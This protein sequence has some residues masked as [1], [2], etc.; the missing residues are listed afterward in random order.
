MSPVS[1]LFAL[2]LV[3]WTARSSDVVVHLLEGVD[4]LA[5]RL[6]RGR[7]PFD[8]VGRGQVLELVQARRGRR[9]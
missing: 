5:E 4:R 7:L 1:S 9:S 2:T 6:D 8:L 3:F